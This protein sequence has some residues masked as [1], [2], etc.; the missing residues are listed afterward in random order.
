MNDYFNTELLYLNKEITR[1]K[2]SAQ[3]SAA[4]LVTT[5]QTVRID[6]NLELGTGI[7]VG[8]PQVAVKTFNYEI[9]TESNAIIT[10]TLDWY[11]AD[12]SQAWRQPPYVYAR[13]I[14]MAEVVL[15]NGNA[16]IRL[17]IYGTNVGVNNDAE[18]V[19]G[20]QTVTVTVNLTVRC[21][22]NFIIRE[23]Q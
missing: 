17:S 10:S 22:D 3:R 15:P 16:G 13:Y 8:G 6:A 2:T 9:V 4:L 19:A 14:D 20:G 18:R 5:S 21:S 23:Y 11:Y 12:I 1:L 7:D